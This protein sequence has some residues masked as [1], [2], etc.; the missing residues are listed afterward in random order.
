M[1]NQI[2][3]FMQLTVMLAETNIVISKLARLNIII[4]HSGEIHFNFPDYIQ[5]ELNKL[6]FFHR[7]SLNQKIALALA[8]TEEDRNNHID[9]EEIAFIN[10][11]FGSGIAGINR[12]EISK[13]HGKYI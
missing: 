13:M 7:L 11:F 12:E 9:D 1:L 6:D 3:T 4:K 8:C 5:E 10:K 2:K